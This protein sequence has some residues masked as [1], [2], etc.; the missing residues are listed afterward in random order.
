[1]K[2]LSV[3]SFFLVA[4][5]LCSAQTAVNPL[6]QQNVLILNHDWRETHRDI[7]FRGFGS[8]PFSENGFY[9]PA[10]HVPRFIKEYEYSL[11]VRNA[12]TKTIRTLGWNY[13][14]ID[15]DTEKEV[16][17]HHF[18]SVVK[19]T[20]GQ[21]RTIIESSAAPPT[22]VVTAS[23]LSR[24]ARHPFIEKIAIMCIG[25]TDGSVW[26]NDAAAKDSCQQKT[27]GKR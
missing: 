22:K 21:K 17:A 27:T 7:S 20:Q 26:R 19:I 12:G 14:F 1:M 25:Y 3:L 18:Q 16:T 6:A 15:P 11:T 23:A 13:I 9:M 8:P 5:I 2:L 4:A 10:P 24:D